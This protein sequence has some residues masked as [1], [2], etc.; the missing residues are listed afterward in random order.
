MTHAWRSPLPCCCSLYLQRSPT[1]SASENGPVFDL[2]FVRLN[3]IKHARILNA[4]VFFFNI[5]FLTISIRPI[6]STSDLHRICS[7]GR[8][9]AVDERSE[10]SLLIPQETLTWHPII[11]WLYPQNFLSRYIGYT[12]RHEI[13]I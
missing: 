6:I 5:L 8:T 2:G 9:V 3:A 11:C 12:K 13:G 4:A 7:S 10:V 1:T